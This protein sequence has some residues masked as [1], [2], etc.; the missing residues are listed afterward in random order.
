MAASQKAS[1]LRICSRRGS[2]LT[3]RPRERRRRCLE[4]GRGNSRGALREPADYCCFGLLAGCF[5]ASR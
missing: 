1:R 3:R 5:A 4:L 2:S